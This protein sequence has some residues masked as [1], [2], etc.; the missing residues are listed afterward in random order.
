MLILGIET[1][2][3]ATSVS[4]WSQQGRVAGMTLVRDRGHVE[5]LMPAVLQTAR[6][7]DVSIDQLTGVA[8]GLGPGLF[9][10]LRVGVATAK[11]LAQTLE[12]PI[13]GVSSLDLLAFSVRF[14]P[15][16]ICACVDARRG[17]VFAAFYRKGPGGLRR[18]NE[19]LAWEPKALAAEAMGHGERLLF[20]GNGAAVYPDA[21]G[22]VGEVAAGGTQFPRA[23]ALCEL[24]AL[25]FQR[26]ETTP[27]ALVEPLY[28]RRSDAEIN[29]ERRGVVI[30]RPDRVKMSKKVLEGRS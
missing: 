28:V 26:E 25:R 17:E 15:K 3:A 7:A 4:F 11:T 29:W 27:V 18:L 22:G 19:Y 16:L 12:V 6:L 13:V 2:T 30:E 1:S 10:S 5:F 8:V 23:E 20:V 24:A 21:F 14:T 9:T